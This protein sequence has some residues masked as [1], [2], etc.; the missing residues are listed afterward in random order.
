MGKYFGTDGI[1]GVVNVEL[2]GHLAFKVGRAVAY[3]LSQQSNH[4]AKILIGKDTRISSDMLEAALTAGI[5]SSGAD[6]E[7]L[8]VIP[9]PAVAHLTIKHMA[10][11]GIVISASHN[12]YEHN[13]IKI[14]AGS[15]YKLSDELEARIE[16]YIDRVDDLPRATHDKIGRV[17]P[18]EMDPIEEYTDYLAE[19]IPGDLSGLRVAVDCA[20]GASSATASTLFRKLNMDATIRYYEPDGCNINAHC[21]STHLEALQK[22][23]KEG[24]FDVGV[25]FDGDADRC[26]IVD[27][28]GEVLDGDR[29]MAVCAAELKKQ[30]KL[31]G[32]A[33][34]ATILS[35]MGLHAYAREKGMEIVCA[36]VGD[37]YVL[38]KMLENGYILGG[39]QSGHVIFLEYATTGDGELTAVQF[40]KML[41][42]SG[43]RASEIAAEVVPW[44]QVMINV[45]V[46]TAL[47]YSL[48]ERQEVQDA[49]AKEEKTLGEGR[50]LVRPSGT[51]PLVRVMV[52]GVNK[53]QVY[54]AAESVAQVIESII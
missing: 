22:L 40:L 28:K 45:T 10:D 50:I 24:G 37:R 41:K 19:T 21:G 11:A 32:N 4:R 42:D 2:D 3:A 43:K 33:F 26:L 30:N 53:D 46:P 39:E 35:N 34:V 29:I 36:N 5:C 15:G 16:E 49:I 54:G 48:A 52:E 23:V 12:P 25:A 31:R 1:R 17:L 13:G 51:E 14:F 20:N 47:K 27:D 44:P 7:S 18:L 38:E 9:T 6:V 8:G